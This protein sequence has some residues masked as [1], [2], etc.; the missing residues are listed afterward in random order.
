[1]QLNLVE[2]KR[3][4]SLEDYVC[5][6]IIGI[7]SIETLESFHAQAINLGL[8]QEDQECRANTIIWDCKRLTKLYMDQAESVFELLP[9]EY[10]FEKVIQKLKENE[11]LAARKLTRTPKKKK[12]GIN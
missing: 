5:S 2:A 12:N 3:M 4:K 7:I 11:V 9:E 6:L 8:L 1:M 10:T